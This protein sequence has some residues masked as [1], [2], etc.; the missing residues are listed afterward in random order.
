MRARK[1]GDSGRSLNKTSASDQRYHTAGDEQHA[2]S[3]ARNDG[4]AARP[5]STP[6]SGMQTM[7]SVMAMAAAARH[8][9]GG[10]R[11]RI[12]HGAAETEA[13][14]KAYH[15]QHG[16]AV[17][18]RHETGQHGEA[19]DAGEQCRG[20]ADAVAEDAAEQAADD[21]AERRGRGGVGK[22]RARQIPSRIIAGT[23]FDRSWLSAPSRTIISA[24][25]ATSNR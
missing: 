17:N 20:S 4:P 1:R 22:C 11:G 10:E 6:P 21:H 9:L 3:V 7:V 8:E 19:G 25:A 18:H 14:E 24:V 2:P 15:R 16:H 13:G 12:G 5:A 23:A